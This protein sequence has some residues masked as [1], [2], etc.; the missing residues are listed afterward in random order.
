MNSSTQTSLPSS[1]SGQKGSDSRHAKN[2]L[3]FT[4]HDGN[5]NVEPG[6]GLQD[7]NNN[8]QENGYFQ[9]GSVCSFSK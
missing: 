8:D 5:D 7:W 4:Q 6:K 3:A 1:T 9:P 2:A